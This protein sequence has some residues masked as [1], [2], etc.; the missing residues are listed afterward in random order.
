MTT[1]SCFPCVVPPSYLPLTAWYPPDSRAISKLYR[2]STSVVLVLQIFLMEH[3][4]HIECTSDIIRSHL[5][6]LELFRGGQVRTSHRAHLVPR[7]CLPFIISCLQ[8]R[9]G[10]WIMP[11]LLP[12]RTAAAPVPDASLFARSSRDPHS[13]RCPSSLTGRACFFTTNYSPQS[14]CDPHLHLPCLQLYL[15]F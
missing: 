1:R 8:G 9:R 13:C 12:S 5:P 15:P 4:L 3:D 11:S 2:P 14:R 7:S 10:R 6:L